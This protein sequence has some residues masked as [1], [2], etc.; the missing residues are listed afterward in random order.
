MHYQPRREDALRHLFS[1][2]LG[3]ETLKMSYLGPVLDPSG[4]IQESPD[5][6]VSD[7]R[8]ETWRRLKC[9]FKLAPCSKSEFVDNGQ[10]DIAIVWEIRSPATKSSLLK[11]LLEQNG[12]HEVI[13]LRDD[14]AVFRNLPL[15]SPSILTELEDQAVRDVGKVLLV[16]VKGRAGCATAYAAYIAAA[17][18]PSDFN[19]ENMLN[20]LAKRFP[21]VRGMSP[22]GRH[23]V[24]T[25]LLQ[26]KPPLI[27]R[28]SHH[29]Y[30]WTGEIN[31]RAARNRIDDI[32]RNN[33]GSNVPDSDTVQDFTNAG[34]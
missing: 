11:D 19:L 34:H 20:E 22:R 2:R 29:R 10:F 21:E 3:E 4:M 15:Y 5:A 9:E 30:K 8:G 18:W 27:C 14:Y 1:S 32:I 28:R 25:S 16:Q 33:F 6:V 31:A 23:N 12:C 13:V 24:V 7:Q 26:T 17:I